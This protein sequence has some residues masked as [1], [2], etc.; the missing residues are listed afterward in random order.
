MN[1]GLVLMC[2]VVVVCI[3][4][5]YFYIGA[6]SSWIKE[7][8]KSLR[9]ELLVLCDAIRVIGRVRYG[10]LR[11]F[12]LWETR[13]LVFGSLCSASYFYFIYRYVWVLHGQ[14]FD[15]C[16]FCLGGNGFLR[17]SNVYNKPVSD[18]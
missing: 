8:L 6:N 7:W 12:S 1:P 5:A 17:D 13:R 4:I 15:P 10:F 9:R 18:Q 16:V 14:G 11:D 2:I 3:W